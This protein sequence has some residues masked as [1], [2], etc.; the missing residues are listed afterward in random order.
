MLSKEYQLAT[1]FTMMSTLSSC[2]N[3]F[4]E[5][6]LVFQVYRFVLRYM[7]WIILVV[8]V[9]LVPIYFVIHPT[10]SF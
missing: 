6:Q 7:Q 4:S 1:C 8:D 2:I 10:L 5:Y 9:Y 3:S